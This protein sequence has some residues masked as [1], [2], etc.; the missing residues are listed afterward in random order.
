MESNNFGTRFDQNTVESFT[1]QS[2]EF[3]VPELIGDSELYTQLLQESS[4][5]NELP[6]ESYLVQSRAITKKLCKL[7]VGLED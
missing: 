4:T 2:R 5:V 3:D 7:Q 6:N 1:K